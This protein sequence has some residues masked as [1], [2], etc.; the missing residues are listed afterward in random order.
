MAGL[1]EFFAGTH[2]FNADVVDRT[3]NFRGLLITIYRYQIGVSL[4]RHE[5]LEPA[6]HFRPYFVPATYSVYIREATVYWEAAF[7]A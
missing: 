4:L 6:P 7:T 1:E 5:S 3:I 2:I